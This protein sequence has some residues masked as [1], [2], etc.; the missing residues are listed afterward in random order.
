LDADDGS[1]QALPL[2]IEGVFGQGKDVDGADFLASAVL[3]LTFKVVGGDG[4]LAQGL[5]RVEQAG[6]VAFELGDQ[7]G[8]S[9]MGKLEGFLRNTN[10]CGRIGI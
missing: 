10:F 6:L 3:F 5:D 7:G 1:Q 8:T 9:L 4:A 2:G